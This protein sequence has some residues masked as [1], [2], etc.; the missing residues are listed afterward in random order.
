[1]S[2]EGSVRSQTDGESEYKSS[3]QR[4]Q[5][6]P[7]FLEER[8]Q[9]LLKKSTVEKQLV[10][11]SRPTQE[12]LDF[13]ESLLSGTE[14]EEDPQAIDTTN[15]AAQLQDAAKRLKEQ[16]EALRSLRQV[17]AKEPC[18]DKDVKDVKDASSA[19][20]ILK[21]FQESLEER[22][23]FAQARRLEHQR[24][25]QELETA[26]ALE[27]EQL[28]AE[29]E[30]EQ[31]AA[32]ARRDA[33][34]AWF[35]EFS[36]NT[37]K[38]KEAA[39]RDSRAKAAKSFGERDNYWRT[40]WWR[41]VPDSGHSQGSKHPRPPNSSAHRTRGTHGAQH[42]WEGNSKHFSGERETWRPQV[43]ESRP[44]AS[45]ILRELLLHREESLQCRK[46]IWRALCLRWHPDKSEGGDKD[47]STR[48]FQQLSELKP[49]F[50]PEA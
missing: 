29:I 49:W 16:A 50:L 43:T 48:V 25:L 13:F 37:Q 38:K 3:W 30:R 6:M 11:G 1:M 24:R 14:V 41:Y 18:Q 17:P 44:E 40:R 4:W 35:E 31:T 33:Q 8:R 7:G 19:P 10:E 26:A 23:A 34:Q 9:Q 45:A 46:K 20:Q 22:E 32:A 36:Q 28:Q 27:R 47:L 21:S 12:A 39:E 2:D 5:S 42:S 15:G